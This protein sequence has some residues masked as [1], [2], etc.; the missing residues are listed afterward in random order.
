MGI[1]GLAEETRKDAAESVGE[2]NAARWLEYYRHERGQQ[3]DANAPPRDVR[4]P[5]EI[6]R[7]SRSPPEPGVPPQPAKRE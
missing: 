6:S 5:A 4:A 1:V 7:E 2:G 3:W